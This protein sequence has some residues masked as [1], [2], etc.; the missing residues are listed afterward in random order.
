M[1]D[2]EPVD[3]TC[4]ECRRRGRAGVCV[5]CTWRLARAVAG[6]SP[7][8]DDYRGPDRDLATLYQLAVMLAEDGTEV[9]GRVLCSLVPDRAYRAEINRLTNVFLRSAEVRL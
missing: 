6:S 9:I 3:S 5:S 2:Y 8:S 7:P 4:A 1:S